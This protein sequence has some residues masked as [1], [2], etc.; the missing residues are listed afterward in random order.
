[1]K[2]LVVNSIPVV[3]Q[4]ILS[5]L[6]RL[7]YQR[8]VD[9]SDIKSALYRIGQESHDLIITDLNLSDGWGLTFIQAVRACPRNF[10][11]RLVV[12]THARHTDRIDELKKSGVAH[13][14]FLK[15]PGDLKRL[16]EMISDLFDP[17]Q[18]EP[19]SIEQPATKETFMSVYGQHESGSTDIV[20]DKL[21][22]VFD[23]ARLS[24]CLDD[25]LQNAK[26]E[27]F[28]AR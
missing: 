2:V 3:R 1:M 25:L 20:D 26:L 13:C 8:A 23:N 18:G 24:I 19:E 16:N 22:M 12:I 9:V 4:T 10:Q 14:L 28:P 6:G 7:G 27:L 5:S 15:K 11:A 21:V 17:I